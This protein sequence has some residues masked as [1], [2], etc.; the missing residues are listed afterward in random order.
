MLANISAN[1]MKKYVLCT[2]KA[3]SHSNETTVCTSS[4]THPELVDLPL[5]LDPQLLHLRHQLGLALG[6]RRG[7]PAVLRCRPD[8]TPG[9]ALDAARGEAAQAA[10]PVSG[11]H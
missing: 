11:G 4:A 2:D 1:Y 10:G 7:L 8:V 5:H 9:Q 6:P 3:G